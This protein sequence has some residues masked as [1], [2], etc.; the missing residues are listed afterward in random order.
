MHLFLV[1]SLLLLVR[2]LFLVAMHLFLVASFLPAKHGASL[3]LSSNLKGRSGKGPMR[4]AGA[5]R[6]EKPTR[7]ALALPQAAKRTSKK[8]GAC[9]T[10]CNVLW[11]PTGGTQ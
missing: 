11:F 7:N 6:L 10:S 9:S 1:A 8:K 2:H 4:S 5:G 3:P